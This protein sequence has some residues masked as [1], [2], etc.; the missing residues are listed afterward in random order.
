MSVAV[1]K[2]NPALVLA[3]LGVVF[4]DIGTSPLYS[5]QTALWQLREPDTA[6]VLGI[7]SLIIWSL[8]LLVTVKYV[9]IVMRADYHGEGGVFALLALL[10]EKLGKPQGLKLPFYMLLLLFGAALLF[11]DG[12]ITPAISVL[13]AMEGLESVSPKLEQ[14]IIPCTVGILVVLFTI[15]RFGTGRLGFVFG[16]VMLAWFLCIG[17]MG[18]Y[19]VIQS[20]EVFQA[21]NPVYALEVIKRDGWSALMLMGAVVL[22]VT[23]VEALYADMG[24]FSHKAISIAWHGL[25]L[26]CLVLNY[27]GQAA[28]VLPSPALYQDERDP[29]FSMVPDGWA[30]AAL[31]GLATMA[32]VIASQALISG[33]FSLTAQAQ[34]LEFLPRFHVKHTSREERGQV[35]VPVVN[36]MLGFACILLVL[37]FRSSK[38]LAA[39]YGL[40]VVGTMVITTVSLGL[41][42]RKCWSWR[43][44]Q[45][46]LLVA[47]LL[48]IEV[49]FLLACMTKFPD[50]GYFPVL[51]AALLM[52]LMLI[53]HKGR[54]IVL[55][56][57]R[58]CPGSV[59][60][61]AAK[62]EDES[63]V[64]L[65]GQLVFITSNPNPHY[66]SAR[67]FEFLRRGGVLRDQVVIMSLVNAMESDVNMSQRIEAREISP[68]LWHIV[69]YHGYMQEPRAPGILEHGNRL[70]DGKISKSSAETFYILPRELIVEYV[71]TR[72]PR[73]QRSVFGVL[74]RNVS[75]A[76]DYFFIP[77]SQITEFTWML[78]A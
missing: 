54:S 14:Y 62:L 25:A 68:R 66:A 36:W 42:A 12:T 65:P 16:W 3:A 37:T 15:Q 50:G 73:W 40:A 48:C 19:W 20:P 10:Q 69:A 6:G 17:G 74:N 34:E 35:Y 53:W 71:G 58:S 28:L 29:F 7:P 26:P 64:R 4:G 23:G 67:A 72:L 1:K 57:L 21:F 63:L 11:G 31:V 32:T 77:Y 2:T 44:W 43:G 49:P 46:A 75:Y 47:G 38:A 9:L 13:S 78:R 76:P 59:D 56:H 22:A 30:T 51:V 45:V 60:E 41:V 55:Q 39:A 8:L 5:F 33:V 70:S 52:T 18:L 61:L 24:H 27:L